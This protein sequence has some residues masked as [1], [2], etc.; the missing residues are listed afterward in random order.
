MI[1]MYCVPTCTRN[2]NNENTRLLP[3]VSCGEGMVNRYN[4]IYI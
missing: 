1:K 2:N 4:Y 3:D